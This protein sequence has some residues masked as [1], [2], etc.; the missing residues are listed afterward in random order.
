[1]CT[2][3]CWPASIDSAIVVA[4]VATIGRCYIMSVASIAASIS[5]LSVSFISFRLCCVISQTSAHCTHTYAS[6]W[7]GWDVGVACRGP[8]IGRMEGSGG[9]VYIEVCLFVILRRWRVDRSFI[10]KHQSKVEG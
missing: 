6:M 8:D 5:D 2:N 9:G 1:M 7:L 10:A 4:I 3:I